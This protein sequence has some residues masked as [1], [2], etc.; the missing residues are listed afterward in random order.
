MEKEILTN[1][2]LSEVA[3]GVVGTDAGGGMTREKLDARLTSVGV[4]WI[5]EV[6]GTGLAQNEALVP[7]GCSINIGEEICI[8]HATYETKTVKGYYDPKGSFTPLAI[9]VSSFR[10]K[11]FGLTQEVKAWDR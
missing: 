2:E 5:N 1:D 7:M 4:F 8:C 11:G 3:G 10:S 6:H 9:V